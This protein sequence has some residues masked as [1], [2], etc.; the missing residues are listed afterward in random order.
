MIQNVEDWNPEL[1]LKFRNERT[2]PSVDL[3]N[4]IQIG[5]EPENII[6]IGCG[7]GNRGQILFERWPNAKFLGIDS[8]QKMIEK[9]I[10]DHPDKS[11]Q[12]ADAA[13]YQSETKYDIVYS[14][15]TIQWIPNHEQLIGH[16]YDLLTARGVLAVQIPKFRDMIISKDIDNVANKIKWRKLTEHCSQLYTHHDY[17]FYYDVLSSIFV[18][19]EMWETFYL[20]VLDSHKL[21]VEMIKSTGMKPYLDSL[22]NEF[23]KEEFE[24]DV[25]TEVVNH[26]P[27]Q[28]NGKVIFP[29]KRLFMIGFN[30][31]Q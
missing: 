20:H 30:K 5:F 3:V 21:I 7:P 23:E 26:Y 25:L 24:N 14:N 1:Y 22:N 18:S 27:A 6:D 2:Q 16:L 8:S 17:N 10:A 12:I 28:S 11:W 9:A 15:A 29:F 31:V 19:I 4:R 13:I